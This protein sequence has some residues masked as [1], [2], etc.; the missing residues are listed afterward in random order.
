MANLYDEFAPLYHLFFEDW[1]ASVRRQGQQLSSILRSEWPYHESVLDVSC[2]IGTQAIALAMQG[3]RVRGSDIANQAIERAKVEAVA[4]GQSIDFST[5][6]MRTAHAH[7]GTGYD[8]VIS[9]DNSV[10]HLLSDASKAT[11]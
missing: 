7:H 6:D 5:C 4:R 3:Y 2:G 9:C 10:P 1:D 8:L 11:N